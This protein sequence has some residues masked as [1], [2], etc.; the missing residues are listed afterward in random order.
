MQPQ[1][2]PGLTPKDLQQFAEE[3]AASLRK[4]PAT[5]IT[6]A[7]R[8]E[9]IR[10]TLAEEDVNAY[11]SGPGEGVW[12]LWDIDA[13]IALPL[14]SKRWAIDRVSTDGVGHWRAVVSRGGEAVDFTITI[15]MHPQYDRGAMGYTD[16]IY[17]ARAGRLILSLINHCAEFDI[18]PSRLDGTNH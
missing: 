9:Y 7:E 11:H 5:H 1:P 6:E 8:Q 16:A 3:R 14:L 4:I 17:Q 10:R 18:H 13:R 2:M 15:G 12:N